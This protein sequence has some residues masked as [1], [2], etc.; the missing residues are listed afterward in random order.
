MYRDLAVFLILAWDEFL[1][2]WLS[3]LGKA[4]AVIP[5]GQKS[6]LGGGVV[7]ARGRH[8]SLR[9]QSLESVTSFCTLYLVTNCHFSGRKC[10]WYVNA[11]TPKCV[12][13]ESSLCFYY[14]KLLSF[15]WGLVSC[16]GEFLSCLQTYT[17]NRDIRCQQYCQIRQLRPL[18]QSM[19][20]VAKEWIDFLS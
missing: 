10:E 19:L 13:S 16:F 18:L 3:N 12:R 20:V 5:N 7:C 1:K 14:N 9:E 4:W 17:V 6:S 11:V 15:P 8:H 2:K